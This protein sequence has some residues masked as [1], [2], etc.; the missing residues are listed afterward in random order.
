MTFCPTCEKIG[1][2]VALSCLGS[3]AKY[4]DSNVPPK[5]DPTTLYSSSWQDSLQALYERLQN[6]YSNCPNEEYATRLAELKR[7]LGT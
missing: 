3:Q 6:E 2:C 4:D 5:E 1:V 7:I